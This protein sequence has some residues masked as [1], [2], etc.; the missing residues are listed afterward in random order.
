MILEEKSEYVLIKGANSSFASILDEINAE[1]SLSN[2]HI[3]LEIS[4]N[5]N[6]RKDEISLLLEYSQQ[7]KSNGTSFVV[8]K[9]NVSID[10]FDESINIVPTLHEAEDILEMEAIERDLGI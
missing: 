3:I 9:K 1:N 6:I 5:I 8:V 10:D 4:E 7:K 2:K